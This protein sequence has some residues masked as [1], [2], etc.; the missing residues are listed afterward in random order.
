MHAIL[1][2]R[3]WANGRFDCTLS[4]PRA[5]GSSEG[6]GRVRVVNPYLPLALAES[7]Q[8]GGS[9]PT[10]NDRLAGVR[11]FRVRAFPNHLAFYVQRQNGIEIVRVIHGSRDLDAAL[12]DA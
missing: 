11:V 2:S 10:K 6:E 3:S 4:L 9:Y 5:A 7:P 1:R 8:I 12:R